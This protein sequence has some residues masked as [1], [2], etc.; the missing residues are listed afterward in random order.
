MGQAGSQITLAYAALT[1]MQTR[2]AHICNFITGTVLMT[3]KCHHL[4]MPPVVTHYRGHHRTL[5]P[6]RDINLEAHAIYNPD[7]NKLP[8]PGAESRPW[9]AEWQLI[10]YCGTNH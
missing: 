2:L 7:I 5:F 9:Q 10:A 8:R 6:V 3:F 4:K 1:E